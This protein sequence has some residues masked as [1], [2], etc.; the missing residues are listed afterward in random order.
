[1][2]R[3]DLVVSP[4]LVFRLYIVFSFWFFVIDHIYV[5]LRFRIIIVVL[6]SS[7]GIWIYISGVRSVCV[8]VIVVGVGPVPILVII[9][10]V[11][12]RKLGIVVLVVICFEIVSILLIGEL[13]SLH[14]F[15]VGFVLYI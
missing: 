3:L 15:I 11:I 10:R 13:T 6:I 8:L 4:V 1:M 7:L 2:K 12:I 14:W 5:P 9:N